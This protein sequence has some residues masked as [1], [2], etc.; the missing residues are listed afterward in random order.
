MIEKVIYIGYLKFS[1][2]LSL[3][4]FFEDVKRKNI[5]VEYW[6]LSNIFF[7]KNKKYITSSVDELILNNHN[8]LKKLF[9]QQDSK[10][11]LYV[12]TITYDYESIFLYFLLKKY[13]CKVAFFARG[14]IPSIIYDKSHIYKKLLKIQLI[15]FYIIKFL[16]NKLSVLLK[17]LNYI[18]TIDFVYFAGDKSFQNLG[19]GYEIDLFKAKTFQINYFDYDKVLE[20]ENSI[21][22]FNEPYCVFHD[23]YLPYHPDFLISKKK[24]ILPDQY[25]NDLNSFFSKI[26]NHFKV[27]VKIAAHPKAEKYK[28]YNPF[29]KREIFF[30]QTAQLCK[31]SEFSMLHV[32]TSVS[33]P[34]IYKKPILFLT[35]NQI[36]NNMFSYN[37]WIRNF[38][39]ELGTESIN[40]NDHSLKKII[41]DFNSNLYNEYIYNYITRTNNYKISS[42]QVFINSLTKE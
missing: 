6:N 17:Y 7:K 27:K 13:N 21:N 5:D 12:S 23:E 16:K 18:K 8:D 22:Y 39:N 1:K 37:Q 9:K 31:F 30:G 25:Y 34:V 14:A 2:N 29:N 32:S 26:E 38:A 33:F 42:S 28:D 19:L 40:I 10:K 24:T 4:F 15:P 3:N 36:I 35:S 11:T 41:M 20:I